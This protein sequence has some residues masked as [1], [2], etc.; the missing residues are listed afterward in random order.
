LLGSGLIV[1][2]PGFQLAGQNSP[3]L[4][5]YWKAWTRRRV[6]KF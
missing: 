6:W 4:S 5:V 2:L 1:S 3:C